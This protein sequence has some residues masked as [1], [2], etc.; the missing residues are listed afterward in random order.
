MTDF[1][2][3]VDSGILDYINKID[4][5]PS[6][7]TTSCCSGMRKDHVGEMSRPYLIVATDLYVGDGL[8]PNDRYPHETH[9]LSLSVYRA[10]VMA[11]WYADFT[12]T[13]HKGMSGIG[14]VYF[15]TK[16]S[17]TTYMK[18]I[19]ENVTGSPKKTLDMCA[20]ADSKIEEELDE[21]FDTGLSDED[22]DEKWADLY[23]E[24]KL[25]LVERDTR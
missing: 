14:G 11:G 7:N 4:D 6:I 1:G 22:I 21:H 23:K 10:G 24:L 8:P 25:E 18:M 15:S 3:P 12:I 17:R 5:L 19:A 2:V 9:S 16:P 13:T 20:R